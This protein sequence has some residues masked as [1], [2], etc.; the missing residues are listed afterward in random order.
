MHRFFIKKQ[1]IESDSVTI[2]GN[3]ARQISKVLRLVKGD[4]ITVMDGTN[5][6]YRII[7]DEINPRRILGTIMEKLKCYGEPKCPITLYQGVLKGHKF[8]TVLQKGTELGITRFV[9]VICERTI[10]RGDGLS[11]DH[12]LDRYMTIVREA[13]EQS[14]RGVI[15]TIGKTL[16]LDEALRISDGH[17]IILWEQE[18]AI[19][20]NDQLNDKGLDSSQGI[21]LFVGPEGG[22]T[23]REIRCSVNYGLIPVTLGKRILRAETASLAAVVLVLSSLGEFSSQ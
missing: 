12:K 15:P 7:L 10:P 2:E 4:Y 14:H 23:N 8:E 21:S 13:S 20:I 6:E 9:P 1:D 22:F 18:T 19:G 16:P 3:I 17:R 5:W 11:S